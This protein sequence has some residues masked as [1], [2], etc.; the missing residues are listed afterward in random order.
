M[1]MLVG[2]LPVGTMFELDLDSG[3]SYLA[4]VLDGLIKD[5]P[6]L[7]EKAARSRAQE[8]DNG[9]KAAV[10]QIQNDLERHI[11]LNKTLGQDPRPTIRSILSNVSVA[12]RVDEFLIDTEQLRDE[13][14][15]SVDEAKMAASQAQI[16][17]GT[18]GE[19]SLSTYFENYAK[20]QLR[21]SNLFRI[22]TIVTIIAAIA[23]AVVGARDSS[24]DITEAIYHVA[25]VAGVAGLAT[26]FGRQAG[27]HRRDGSW[28]KAL[29]IQLQSFPAFM[30]AIPDD[31][32]KAL[33]YEAFAKRVLGAPPEAKTSSD[34]SAEVMTQPLIDAVLRRASSGA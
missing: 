27:H 15:E 32:T 14:R 5:L 16:A 10:E 20:Q 1:E 28:A 8:I 12:R 24:G 4:D 2:V 17:A 34:T 23:I 13:A 19:A 33:V 9:I 6:T 11:E 21:S 26:Y 18:A 31:K 30:A 22:G 3:F 29:Q 25:I 7:S